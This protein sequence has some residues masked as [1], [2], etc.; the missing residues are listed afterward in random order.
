MLGRRRDFEIITHTKDMWSL[1]FF[2]KNLYEEDCYKIRTS[3]FHLRRKEN[4]CR[5][6][7][8]I[9]WHM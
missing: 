6:C 4:E 2:N 5:I 3:Y 8:E 7:R 9:G 1:F